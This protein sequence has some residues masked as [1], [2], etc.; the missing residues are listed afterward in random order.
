VMEVDENLNAGF[1]RSVTI[2]FYS[3]DAVL[4][5]LNVSCFYYTFFTFYYLFLFIS[6]SRT[7][8]AESRGPEDRC[9]ASRR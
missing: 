6:A 3:R 4:A 7:D 5:A 8:R 1:S 9:L 2:T